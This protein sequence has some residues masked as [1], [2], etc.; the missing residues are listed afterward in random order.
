[1]RLAEFMTTEVETVGASTPAESAWDLMKQEGVRHLVVM[2]GKDIVGIVSDRDLGARGGA[3]MRKGRTV[4][5]LMSERPVTVT[6][7]TSARD[8]ANLMR[9]RSIGCLPVVDGKKLVGIVT[10]SDMLELIGR[11]VEKPVARAKRFT[12][13][14]KKGG[15]GVSAH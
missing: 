2:D 3:A 9:G 4:S 13:T 7:T 1:M 12:L 11:G 14:H 10:T 15:R 8:A 5:E 6:P